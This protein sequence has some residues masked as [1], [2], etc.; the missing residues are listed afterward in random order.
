MSA[1]QRSHWHCQISLLY[2]FHH[3]IFAQ[4][5]QSARKYSRKLATT[6]F[7]RVGGQDLAPERT[8]AGYDE[9][10]CKVVGACLIYDCIFD[11]TTAATSLS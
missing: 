1:P 8:G 5:I 3:S 4:N 11:L 9:H 10:A 6:L 7:T 2:V